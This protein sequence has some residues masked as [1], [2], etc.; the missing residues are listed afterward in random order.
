MVS[1]GETLK[2]KKAY[3]YDYK[4]I[5]LPKNELKELGVAT[6][7]HITLEVTSTS[8]LLIE[9]NI[10]EAPPIFSVRNQA[11]L[12][13]LEE[14]NLEISENP[15]PIFVSVPLSSEEDEA[16]TTILFK[17]H[18]IFA[19]TNKNIFGLVPKMAVHHFIVKK[20]VK[21]VEQA[22]RCIHLKLIP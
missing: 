19:W 4:I 2:G 21:T 12:D 1:I 5:A 22:Q 17:F 15:R 6:S 7:Y 11:T 20:G 10:K 8:E 9:E 16:Y 3:Y 18:D 14:V 13:E